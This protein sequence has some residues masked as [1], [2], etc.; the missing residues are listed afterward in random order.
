MGPLVSGSGV[1]Y[2]GSLRWTTYLPSEPFH[3]SELKA[4]SNEPQ[5][6]WTNTG[7]NLVWG[8]LWLWMTVIS[9][10]QSTQNTSLSHSP[11]LPAAQKQAQSL[12]C[13]HKWFL[14]SLQI[15][16]NTGSKPLLYKDSE[17][18]WLIELHMI[19][20]A[21]KLNPNT[22]WCHTKISGCYDENSRQ[23]PHLFQRNF[24]V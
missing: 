19:F 14:P 18:A 12:Y 11:F 17:N 6:C 22:V 8:R 5:L 1:F 15:Y 16:A 20:M 2:G 24:F 10:C 9:L 3:F 23:W 21:Q 7:D 4:F 13:T